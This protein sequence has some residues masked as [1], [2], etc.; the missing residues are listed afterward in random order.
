MEEDHDSI[1]PALSKDR[2]L[3]VSVNRV[4]YLTQDDGEVLDIQPVC[5]DLNQELE[6]SRQGEQ[7]GLN[8]QDSFRGD[9]EQTRVLNSIKEETNDVCDGKEDEPLWDHSPQYLIGDAR[10]N[11][12]DS[13]ETNEVDDEITLALI[14]RKLFET[15]DSDDSVFEGTEELNTKPKR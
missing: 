15:S 7:I 12:E 10:H 4:V 13:L 3:S 14:P 1:P 9:S 2:S 8:S 11:W 5:R 6:T